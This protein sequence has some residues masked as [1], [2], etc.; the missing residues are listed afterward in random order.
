MWIPIANMPLPEQKL[1]KRLLIRLCLPPM[2]VQ[3]IPLPELK[4]L[5]G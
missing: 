3:K 5:G 4:P 1:P 2:W